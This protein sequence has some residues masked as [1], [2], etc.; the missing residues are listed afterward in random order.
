MGQYEVDFNIESFGNDENDIQ[1]LKTA[2]DNLTNESEKQF[3]TIKNEKWF[4]RIID[5]ATLSN[6]KDIRM[7]QQIS[8]IA[9]AQDILIELLKRL[10]AT[11]VKIDNMLL[12]S[13]NQIEQ[14]YNHTEK[15][16]LKVVDLKE[17]MI[18]GI[19]QSKN[20]NDLK[21]IE[22]TVLYNLLQEASKT[23]EHT[24]VEQQQFADSL[25][26]YLQLEHSTVNLP[27]SINQLDSIAIKKVLLQL[28]LEYGFLNNR[29]FNFN[30]N[31][32]EI[33]E[34]FDFGNKTINQIKDTIQNIFQLRGVDGFSWFNPV[35]LEHEFFI[36]LEIEESSDKE[37]EDFKEKE[38]F[39]LEPIIVVNQNE[40]EVIKNK[41]INLSSIITVKGKLKFEN[42]EINITDDF[43]PI[44]LQTGVI[45]F[46][47]CQIRAICNQEYLIGTNDNSELNII[48]TSIKTTTTICNSVNNL[49]ITNCYI[50]CNVDTLIYCSNLNILNSQFKG[51]LDEKN[52]RL[53]LVRIKSEGD[54][55]K[56]ENS[57]FINIEFYSTN[58]IKLWNCN[59]KERCDF[60]TIADSQIS[61]TKF[62]DLKK[63]VNL[64]YFKIT[65]CEIKGNET[66]LFDM[67]LFDCTVKDTN[68]ENI[69]QLDLDN[70]KIENSRIYNILDLEVM[71]SDRFDSVIFDKCKSIFIHDGDNEFYNSTFSNVIYNNEKD[72]Y[73]SFIKWI[74]TKENKFTTTIEGCLFN[75]IK[76]FEGFVIELTCFE[77]IKDV[78]L[79]VEN[80][81]FKNCESKNDNIVKLH[82]YYKPRFS[83][84]IQRIILGSEKNNVGINN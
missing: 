55:T 19:N 64:S 8:N 20:I 50:E 49:N 13:M 71:G 29:T 74:V 82:H 27:E 73:E 23:F 28:L 69:N 84:N 6:K 45:D 35:I 18:Y 10:S 58:T 78:K 68:F 16:A 39:T 66:N 3:Q 37:S 76:V 62:I 42:C 15:L 79:K 67:N 9:Q 5:L 36:D 1:Y 57:T 70:T 72:E 22:K 44:T 33:V 25:F 31:F 46:I 59:F 60:T 12:N 53:N 2:I 77:K 54:L 52:N 75:N 48:N 26:R 21:D 38:L 83:K 65:D 34:M 41:I 80:C 32:E 63:D 14:L 61:N 30:R 11:D 4:T 17:Q 51:F 43:V 24:T 56:V 81:I 47:G 40:T 7:S